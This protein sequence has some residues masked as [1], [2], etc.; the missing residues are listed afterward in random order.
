MS[1]VAQQSVFVENNPYTHWSV[2]YSMSVAVRT[3]W[4]ADE[5]EDEWQAIDIV[6][7]RWAVSG[8]VIELSI[9]AFSMQMEEVKD[10]L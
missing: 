10:V 7:Y 1:D 9:D 4:R 8:A 6:R 3:H 5:E 2:R